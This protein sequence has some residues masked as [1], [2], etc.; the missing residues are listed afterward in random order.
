MFRQT[1]LNLRLTTNNVLDYIKINNSF[2]TAQIES[3]IVG[4]HAC[5]PS[6]IAWAPFSRLLSGKISKGRKMS[7]FSPLTILENQF[8][9]SF[10]PF[11]LDLLLLR[12]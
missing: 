10:F 1:Q 11:S 12:L 9:K 6:G 4:E 7:T 2:N 3:Q 8:S 5:F